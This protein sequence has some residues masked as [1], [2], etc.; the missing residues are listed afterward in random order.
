MSGTSTT[1]G[2]PAQHWSIRRYAVAVALVLF[3][4][5]GAFSGYLMT[6]GDAVSAGSTEVL[7]EQVRGG[8]D[9][10]STSLIVDGGLVESSTTDDRCEAP[11]GSL[12]RSGIQP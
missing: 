3:L 8:G 1:V 11:G 9:G 12:Q 7:I 2:V 5:A 4:M 6:R 10:C